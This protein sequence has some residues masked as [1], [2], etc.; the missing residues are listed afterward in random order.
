VGSLVERAARRSVAER[1]A[2]AR[3]EVARLVDATYRV[4]ERT[5]RTDPT[6]RDILREAGLSTQA[7]YRHFDSKDGLLVA[8]LDDGRRQLLDYLAHQM[9]K[10]TSPADAVRAWIEGVVAQVRDAGAAARTRPFLL[11]QQ[12]LTARFPDEQRASSQLLVDLLV[13][14]LQHIVDT[15][16]DEPRIASMI[17]DLAF[18]TVQTH[19]IQ[20][21]TPTTADIDALVAFALAGA[22]APSGRHHR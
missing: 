2:T 6:I 1:H 21:T 10:A 17:Y 3:D 11:D 9:A 12:R 19:A 5:G 13:E 18:G 16:G 20:R 15:P 14:P 4:V 22:S 8:V 7:F